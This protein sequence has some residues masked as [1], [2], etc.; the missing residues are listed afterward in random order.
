MTNVSLLVSHV[1]V[2]PALEAILASPENRVQGFLG[3]GHVCAVMGY[4]EYLPISARYKVPIVVTGFE[5]LD[6][7]EGMLMTDPAAGR[8]PRRRRKPILA[9]PRPDRQSARA[10]LDRQSLRSRRP[11]VARH[12]HHPEER[13]PPAP[14]VRR[15]R[16]GEALR[17]RRD[18]HARA[19]DLHQR[20]DPARHQEAARLPR[21]RHALQPAASARRDHGLRRGRLRRVLR[22]RPPPEAAGRGRAAPDRPHQPVAAVSVNGGRA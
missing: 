15:A 10:E 18:R 14:G 20:R 1:L 4:S 16:R 2:P 12:R 3:P 9:H 19:R 8:R 5:P 13:L 21:L 7:L 17:R 6:I 11:Q 22:L